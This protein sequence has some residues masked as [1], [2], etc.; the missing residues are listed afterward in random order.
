LASAVAILD[1]NFVAVGEEAEVVVG[2]LVP[3]AGY[4]REI[5]TVS[6]A[7]QDPYFAS[8]SVSVGSG[9]PKVSSAVR[10]DCRVEVLGERFCL[11]VVPCQQ[12]GGRISLYA[13]AT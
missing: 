3:G 12:P 11:H 10:A 13:A 6:W 7:D 8:P 9:K 1:G 5:V 4:G 2:E